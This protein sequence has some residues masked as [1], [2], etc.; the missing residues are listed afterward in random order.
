[1]IAMDIPQIAWELLG[2]SE[3]PT[4]WPTGSKPFG[5]RQLEMV[6][7]W[8]EMMELDGLMAKR[9]VFFKLGYLISLFSGGP[10]QDQ[11]LPLS[12]G[13]YKS[14]KAEWTWNVFMQ[15]GKNTPGGPS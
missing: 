1:M 8:M 10:V 14:S 5:Q 7:P 4:F 2:V 13:S 9:G 6:F 12:L 11:M 3:T 15:S